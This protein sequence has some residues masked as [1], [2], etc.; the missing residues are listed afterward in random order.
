MLVVALGALA[1]IGLM[2]GTGDARSRPPGYQVHGIDV[3]SGHH[4]GKP[5]DWR[6]VRA[7]GV[8]FVT[9]KATEGTA[10]NNPW[11][12]EDFAQARAAGLAIAPYHFYLARSPNT[13][14]AQ[15][16]HFIA[17]LRAVG[18]TGHRPGELP[19]VFDFEWDWQTG[20]CPAYGSVADA[21]AWLDKVERAFG[22]KPIIYTA[23]GFINGC[24][25]GTTAFGSYPLQV[26]DYDGDSPAMPPGWTKWLMWQYGEAAVPG[27]PGI[28]NVD[29]FNGTQAELDAMANRSARGGSVNGDAFADIVS[30]T[31]DGALRYYGNNFNV[32]PTAPYGNGYQIGSGWQTMRHASL[33]DVNGDGYSDVLAVKPDGTLWYYGNNFNV[34][35]TAPY[36][37]GYQIGSGW[38]AMKHFTTGDV[39]G[40]GYADLLA[41]KPDGTL[42]YYGNNFNVSPTAPYG[43]GYQIGS[44]WDVMK[45]VTAGDVNGDGYSDVLAVRPDGALW[46]Y[47]NNFNVSPKAPYGNGY[48]IGSGWDVMKHVTAGDVNGDGHA[49]VLAVRPDGALWYY[50]NNF[51]VSPK[52]P[53]GNGY[54]IGSGWDAM[55]HIL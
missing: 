52:A 17:A 30:V 36:G 28:P 45:H 50:G 42:W 24:M 55:T 37:N 3:Y 29:V 44:G 33:G 2:P 23:K 48:Q 21:K 22:R 43:N 31:S 11:F 46:Y 9:R 34:S 5:I 13:G 7:S 14:A 16:D 15:A 40:D 38:D 32:S 53:Y 4:D 25:G 18:Y 1:F 41:V 35:P 8:D 19:P 27:I 12:A 51:N 6:Q 10:H 47:G 39:N 20:R 54:Q 26:A 49:D